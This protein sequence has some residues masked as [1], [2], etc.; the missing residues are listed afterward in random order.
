MEDVIS[1]EVAKLLENYNIPFY[2]GIKYYNYKGEL[3]GDAIDEIKELV[4]SKQEK[5]EFNKQYKS[6]PA[7]RQSYIQKWLRDK[8]NIDVLAC[9]IRF[10][11][12]EEIAYWTYSIKNIQPVFK[13]YKFSTYEEALEQGIIKSLELI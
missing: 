8:F 3:N 2:F 4:L 5:R 12:Y 6:I 11:G 13:N 1:F 10:T 7:F 9:S